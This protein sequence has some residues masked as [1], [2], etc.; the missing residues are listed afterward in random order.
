MLGDYGEQLVVDRG[1]AQVEEGTFSSPPSLE[2]STDRAPVDA[3]PRPWRSET[4]VV[5]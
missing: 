2:P 4:P 3:E 5:I 1:L